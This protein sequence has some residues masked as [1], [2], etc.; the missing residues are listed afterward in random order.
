MR[1]GLVLAV[2]ALLAAPALAQE[3][4][5]EELGKDDDAMRSTEKGTL[6]VGIILGEPTGISAK[7]YLQDDQAI[8]GAIGFAFVGGGIHV[9]GDYVFHPLILQNRDSFVLPLYVGPGVRLINY[10]DGRDGSNNYVAVGLRAVGGM[11]FD[12]KDVPL[13]AFLELAGILQYGF[14]DGKGFGLDLNVAAG[15]RYYF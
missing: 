13:D 1:S 11:L 7:L 4:G 5:T 10:R 3:S 14:K 8:Q 9:H 6:G 2:I 12:F 15:A